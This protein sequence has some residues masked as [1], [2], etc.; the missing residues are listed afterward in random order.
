MRVGEGSLRGG[1]LERSHREKESWRGGEL[2]RS[3]REKESWR[4]VAKR[5]RA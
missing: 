5:R 2:E 4:G 1:E 3:H